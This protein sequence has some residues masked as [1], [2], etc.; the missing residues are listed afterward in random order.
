MRINHNIAALNTFRQLTRNQS[1]TLTSLERLSSGLRINRAGDDAA[2]LAISE[3]MRGQIRGLNMA[4]RNAQDGISLIQTAEGALNE[5]HA[6]LHR[7]RELSVQAANGTNTLADRQMLQQEVNQLSEELTR[8]AGDTQF[9]TQNLLT[10]DFTNKKIQVGANAG[11]AITLSIS[12]MRASALEIIED[13]TGA[14]TNLNHDGVVVS[15]ANV[16]RNDDAEVIAAF[17][18]DGYYRLVDLVDNGSDGLMVKEGAVAYHE[19]VGALADGAVISK[20]IDIMTQA[21]ADRALTIFDRAITTV[22]SER[23]RLGAT[24]NRLNHTINNLATSSENLVA[25]ES[26]I[27]DADMAKELMEF[28]KNNILTQVAEMMLAQAMQQQQGVLQLLR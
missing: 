9:N 6:V 5:T 24:Q 11:Q 22:S 10:G 8:I 14:T 26:R 21:G 1:A 18:E 13:V 7:M 15:A 3:K 28:A 17:Y 19:S 4:M 12:D 25:A 16:L 23:A 27:R 20:P 2:G